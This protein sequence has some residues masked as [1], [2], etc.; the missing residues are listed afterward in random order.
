MANATHGY[1]GPGG[2]MQGA[3]VAFYRSRSQYHTM[4]DTIRG[5]GPE[6]ARRSLWSLMELL[7]FVGE[8]ILNPR[9]ETTPSDRTESA[10]YFE[11][12]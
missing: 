9:A 5:M 1:Q 12:R 8:N 4:D 10:V 6:G 11:R 2:G 3:D 7:R